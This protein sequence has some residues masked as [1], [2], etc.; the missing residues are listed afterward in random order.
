MKSSKDATPMELEQP[1]FKG[2]TLAELRY[3][4]A[5]V[6]IKREY[7]REKALKDVTKIKQQ[8]PFVGGHSQHNG[9]MGK[10]MR[11]LSFADYF[12]LGLQALR[13]GK[14]IGSRFKKK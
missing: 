4:R 13:I 6:V 11:G 3:R 5:L 7:M 12:I 8:L 1:D 14:K 10:L 9:I 2:Y